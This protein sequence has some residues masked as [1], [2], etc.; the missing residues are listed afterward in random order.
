MRC[1]SAAVDHLRLARRLGDNEELTEAT[2]FS[3]KPIAACL[4]SAAV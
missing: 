2:E 3:L 4:Y 1:D